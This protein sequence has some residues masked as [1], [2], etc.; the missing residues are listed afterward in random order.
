AK[1][2]GGSVRDIYDFSANINPLGPPPAVLQALQDSIG[3]I[4]HYPDHRCGE[5]RRALAVYLGVPE[6]NML[7]GNGASEL[8]YLLGRVIGCRRVV[9]PQPTF[10][11]YGDAVTAAGGTVIE[12]PMREEDG[13]ALPVA[14]LKQALKEADALFICNPNNPTGR[15]EKNLV[16][17][18]VVEEA[19]R[20]GKTVVVDEAF[21]DFVTDAGSCTVLPLLEKY[22]TLVVLYS[23]TKFFAIP[24]LRL[25]LVVAA[26]PLIKKL[27]TL[28]DPW[29]V[30]VFAQAAGAAALSERAYMDQTR[31][32][33]KEEREFLYR[34]LAEL[35]GL[36][37]FPAEANYLL[38]K[39][40]REDLSSTAL[41]ARTA[42]KGVLV[43]DCSTFGGL[44]Y[45][46]IRV[47]VRSRQENMVLL[48][49][50][51]VA[52]EGV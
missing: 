46:Y 28:R 9:I 30:N 43:R 5:L 23:L 34:S 33:V 12:V 15:V 19:A 35:P 29:S 39:I 1:S 40:T 26:T 27:E 49:A 3:L 24:G 38:V 42:Q 47:A 36:S 11:E 25:G 37:P 32:L 31:R 45:R 16:L 2:M 48:E 13:F 10:S 22:P 50:L 8:I 7:P 4:Q 52:M 14:Q 18:S 41:A 51:R 6:E 17:R 21:M 44:G 20:T